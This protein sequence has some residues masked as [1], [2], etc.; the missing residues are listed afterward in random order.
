MRGIVVA[1]AVAQRPSSGGH[2]WVFL[3][4]LLGLRRLGFE[5]LLVD[6]LPDDVRSPMTCVSYLQAVM[7]E[8]DLAGSYCLLGSDGASLAGVTREEALRRIRAA[9]ALLNVMG[10]L[11]D[12]ELLAAAP[13]VVFLDIDPGFPQ[14]WHE[15][16]LHDAFAGHDAFVTI[17]ENIGHA[18]CAI[19]TC[20]LDWITTKQPV[21]LD[22]WPSMA[23]GGEC[24]TTVGSWRG[25]NGPVEYEGHTYGLR[26]HEFRRFAELPRRTNEPF[27][28]ALDIHKD[29]VADLTL[30]RENRWTLLAPDHAAGSPAAY[31]SFIAGSSAELMVAKGMYVDT[32]GGWFSDRSACYLASGRPVLAQDTGLAALYPLGEGLL[33]FATPEEAEEGVARIARDHPWHSRAARGIAEEH[34]DSDRVLPALLAQLGL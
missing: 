10:Y 8:W 30:L 27:R 16:G 29:E 31:R 18:G 21:V 2:T 33:A 17:A 6:R 24:F 32:R 26:V 9:E 7:A 13:L 20:G 28:I 3:Q 5:P 19:P 11:D 25:P 14:M 12:E 22:C 15:L 4:W 34:F 1:G 23:G